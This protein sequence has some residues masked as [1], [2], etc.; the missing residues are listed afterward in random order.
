MVEEINDP[1]MHMVRNSVDHGIETPDARAGRRQA[2]ARDGVAERLP[3]G[4]QRRHRG[5]RTTAPASTPTASSRSA[6]RKGLVAADANAAARGHPPADLRARLLDRR[7]GHRDLGPRRRHGRRAAQHR[8]AARPH[9]H[10]HRARPGHARSS[11]RLPLTLAMLDGLLV[12]RRH[13]A[14]RAAG[15]RRCANRCGR[16][17]SRCTSCRGSPR[18]VQVR[19]S[20]LP[21]VSLGAVLGMGGAALDPSS[22]TVVVVEDGG[23]RI[24]LVVDELLQQAGSRR[25]V[26]RRLVRV[27]ARRRRRR[28]SRRRPGRADSRPARH[29]RDGARRSAGGPPERSPPNGGL[30]MSTH[31]TTGTLSARGAGR[32]ST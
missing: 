19:E 20:V 5:R 13:R 25:E 29:C 32:A 7:Q 3:P 12:A 26:A 8:G 28:H 11:S 24:G 10:P 14:L 31:G 2:G 17:P 18:M 6:R 16:C 27:G 23:S 30:Q 22:A 21:L 4:R 15:R 1:L 9:R